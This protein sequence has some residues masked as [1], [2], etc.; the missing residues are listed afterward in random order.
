MTLAGKIETFIAEGKYNEGKAYIDSLAPELKN[1]INDK[2]S[3]AVI[4]KF[5]DI[6]SADGVDL[7]N[8]YDLGAY[9]KD[10][11]ES[12][13]G[14][15]NLSSALTI[16]KENENYNYFVFLRYFA[17]MSDFSRYHELYLLFR[18]VNNSGYLDIISDLLYDY[19]ST[20]IDPGFE[21][22]SQSAYDFNYN[23]FDPQQYMI[24]D[25]RTAHDNILKNL[26]FI[27]NGIAT[28]D[29]TVTA[30][31][32]SELYK[33]MTELNYMTDIIKAI[34]SKQVLIFKSLTNNDIYAEFDTAIDI[35]KRNYTPGMSFSLDY[36]FGT[37]SDFIDNGDIP[38]SI[39]PDSSIS[40]EEAL[41]IALAAI[42]S[43]KAFKGNV[44]ISVTAKQ[45]IQMTDYK[46]SAGLTAA[47]DIIKA[48]VNDILRSANGT[49]KDTYIFTDGANDRTTIDKLIPPSG[50]DSY[51]DPA[52][53]TEY[54]AVQGSGGYVITITLEAET[55]S[56]SSP[57]VNV[58]SVVN[59]FVFDDLGEVSDYET[60]YQPTSVMVIVNN[61]GL[62]AKMQYILNGVSKCSLIGN[63]GTAAEAEFTFDYKYMYE[64]KYA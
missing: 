43:S 20:G 40:K 64:F 25:F 47:Y 31:A 9:S 30:N 22:Y 36:I 61:D 14:L 11:T 29:A 42:N 58:P 50:R 26:S 57:A 55:G 49:Q 24:S 46:N 34:Y 45:N 41:S 32:I 18:A 59:G 52:A 3:R 8:T 23:E 44:D 38:D 21:K 1:Q 5:N 28:N 12:C 6:V 56:K 16:T 39:T 17:L 54:T 7:Y 48:Q 60:Y 10:F 62:L 63:D 53:V 51:I 15:W 2:V 13:R 4:G 35:P 37:P 33:S 19:D 27:S